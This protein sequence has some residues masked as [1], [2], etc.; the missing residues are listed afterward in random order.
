MKSKLVEAIQLV[1]AGGTI[2]INIDS[3]T[4]NY[5]IYTSGAVTLL[6]NY[7]IQ[8][9]SVPGYNTLITLHYAANLTFGANTVTI[10]GAVMP[11][12]LSNIN[13][14]ITL[15]YNGTTWVVTISPDFETIPFI[16]AN[17]IESNAVTTV[18]IQDDAVT[19]AKLSNITR[20]YL[21]KGGVADAPTLIDAKTSGQILVGDATDVNSVAVSGDATLASTGALTIANNAITTVKIANNNVTLSKLESSLQKEII[22]IPVSFEAGEQ[23]EYS[24]FP[25]YDGDITSVSYVVTKELAA[26][27][28]AKIGIFVNA[29]ATT[30]PQISIPPST[31]INT[32]D[33]LAFSSATFSDG[34]QVKFKTSKLTAGGKAL[35]TIHITR[36]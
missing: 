6:S 31:L 22:V 20:G 3:I 34:D 24:F 1:A 25:S 36:V 5:R 4:D 8:P 29:D 16:T 28:A 2:D 21:I 17:F 12:D 26:T 18:K 14:K 27:D 15:Y 19:L 10:F 35:L 30:P 13:C 7:I 23:A 9:S 32:I 33:D 11:T